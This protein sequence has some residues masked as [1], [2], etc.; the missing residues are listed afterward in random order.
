MY[1]CVFAGS[2]EGAARKY[3]QQVEALAKAIMEAGYKGIVFGGACVGLMGAMANAILAEGGQIIGVLTPEVQKL[4]VQH[5][6][7][8][9]VHVAESYSER[10]QKMLELSVGCIALPGGLGTLDEITE[11]F[12]Q[13]QFHGY[14]DSESIKPCALANFGAFFEGTRTQLQRSAYESFIPEKNLRTICFSAIPKDLV[15]FLANFKPDANDSSPWWLDNAN[16]VVSPNTVAVQTE[17]SGEIS[18]NEVFLETPL[19]PLAFSAKQRDGFQGV[20]P[21]IGEGAPAR[22]RSR[23]GGSSTHE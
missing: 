13:N 17:H 23:L 16:P 9:E 19:R 8:S 7:L 22:R 21:S 11:L 20:M 4:N 12:I 5:S 14:A 10:K 6:C 15:T 18:D 1:I 2:H 3:K